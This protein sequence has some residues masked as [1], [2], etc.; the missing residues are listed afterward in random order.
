MLIGHGTQLFGLIGNP[1]EQ[2]MSP[3]MHNTVFQKLGLDCIYLPFR[4]PLDEVE[5]TLQAIR[6]LG[7]KGVNV[8]VPFKEAVMEYLD[9]LSPEAKACQAV[10]CIKN[11]NGRLTGYNTDGLGFMAAIDEAGVKPQGGK[12]VLI[13][14][15]G[16][17]RSVAY[18]LARAQARHI[19]ILDIEFN[20]ARRLA[21]FIDKINDCTAEARPMDPV[22]FAESCRGA[23][24]LVNCTPV[25][26]TPHI[27]TT[28]AEALEDLPPGAV[29]CDLIYN[30]PVTRFLSLAQA[31][32]HQTLN[33]VAMF[34]YQ[35]VMTWEILLGVRP[36]AAFMK[37]V[38][39]SHLA[40]KGLNPN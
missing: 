24:L 7:F 37:D 2:S 27:E 34:V 18:N 6:L 40:G 38:I 29:V 11:E 1:I 33:G 30:P 22:N 3:L 39:S 19:I 8:T 9:E 31:R 16:A 35:G 25:G 36:P 5:N 4:I 12:A 21:S 10:N 28:P 23:C 15:G 32:G 13:G 20:K 26:M 17:A 14:A